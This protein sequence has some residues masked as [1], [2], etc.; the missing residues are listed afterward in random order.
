MD[1]NILG[2]MPMK[3]EKKYVILV[4]VDMALGYMTWEIVSFDIF[5]VGPDL[6]A[7]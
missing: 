6:S 2:M 3:M 7:L 5:P 4:R 1:T